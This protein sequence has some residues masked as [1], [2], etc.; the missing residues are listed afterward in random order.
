MRSAL[1][2]CDGQAGED[3]CVRVCTNEDEWYV[4][5]SQFENRKEKAHGNDCTCRGIAF[6]LVFSTGALG[7][8]T[9]VIVCPAMNTHMYQHCLT[10]R[11]L[12]VVQE[13]LEYLVRGRKTRLRR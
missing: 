13:D 5:Q 6:I 3:F 1:N 7:P 8:S 2:P 4:R 11:H 10:A 12:T 9:L